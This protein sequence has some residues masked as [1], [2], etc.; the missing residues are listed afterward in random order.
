M[1]CIN[2]CQLCPNLIVS[3]AVAVVNNQLE[4][5]IPATTFNNLQK[6]C[7]V[8]AQTL[9]ATT[10]PLPVVIVDGANT[11]LISLHNRCGVPIYSDQIRT[12]RIYKAHIV[13]AVPSAVVKSNNLC[14]TAFVAP[15]VTGAAPTA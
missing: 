6:I 1:A 10:G 12:R 7:L 5:T 11:T 4:I 2:N 9:P 15:Q 8:I 14:P 13:T 3:T